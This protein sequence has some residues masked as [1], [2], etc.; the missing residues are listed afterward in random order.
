MNHESMAHFICELRK[1]KNLTQKQLADQL[2]I[3]DKAVSKWERGMGYPDISMLS[4]LAEVL[5]VTTNELLQGRR[6]ETPA[7][8]PEI[9]AQNALQYAEKVTMTNKKNA[10]AIVKFI[11]LGSSALAILVCVICDLAISKGLTWS[12]YPIVSI[13]FGC[14]VIVPLF[15]FKE[16]KIKL[17]LL[18]LSVFIIPFLFCIEQIS[19]TGGWMLPLGIPVSLISIVYI[20]V[21][22]LVFQ[23]LE[24]KWYASAL[25]LVLLFCLNWGING[26]VSR[27]TSEPFFDVWDALTTGIVAVLTVVLLAIGHSRAKK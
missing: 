10:Q 6:D 19:G 11:L 5:G 13:L 14:L 7:P 2:Q 26:I 20:W 3:T 23:K 22:F 4:R 27:F 15:H 8:E 12:L 21:A 17:S 18:T 16:H 25:C 1:A 24:N 9:I